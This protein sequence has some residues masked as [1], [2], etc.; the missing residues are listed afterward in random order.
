MRD[1]VEEFSRVVT[2]ANEFILKRYGRRLSVAIKVEDL[3]KI[4]S[5]QLRL[6]LTS[7]VPISPEVTPVKMSVLIIVA[8][9]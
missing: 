7:C 8:S 9:V 1:L 2:D 6:R 3:I 5:V 4:V